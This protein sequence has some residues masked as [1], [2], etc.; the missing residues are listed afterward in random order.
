MEPAHT[1]MLKANI[2]VKLIKSQS[3][4]SI[5]FLSNQ[6]AILQ[7]Q[8]LPNTRIIRLNKIQRWKKQL[9]KWNNFFPQN[10]VADTVLPSCSDALKED[11]PLRQVPKE[12]AGPNLSDLIH[13][14]EKLEQFWA[15]LN[16][17]SA[18]YVS[19]LLLFYPFLS[20]EEIFPRDLGYLNVHR[21]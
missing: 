2:K 8:K 18:G 19:L 1:G 17:H 6:K 5:Y 11:Q 12:S 14:R 15:F 10:I 16:E 3:L 13:D 9:S 21:C 4:N 20:S 7:R